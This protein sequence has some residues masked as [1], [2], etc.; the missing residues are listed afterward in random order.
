MRRAAAT[1][2]AALALGGC[3]LGGPGPDATGEEIYVH[4][5]A[6]CHGIGLEGRVGPALG[7][8]SDAALEGREYI[9]F[10]IAN[11]RGRMP[12]FSLDDDQ[13]AR[14]VDYLREVQED[15]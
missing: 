14:L 9:E 1:V 2:A 6:R 15:E 13:L 10:T 12:S 5:C 8:G 7:P 4:L 11:G 3:T